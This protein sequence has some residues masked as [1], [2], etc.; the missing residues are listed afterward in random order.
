MPRFP[1]RT[2]PLDQPF[3]QA[4]PAAQP[5]LHE[6]HPSIVALVVVAEQVK[7][8]MKRE[9]PKLVELG[10]AGDARLATGD[11]PGDDDVP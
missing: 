5:P 8:A 4:S 6:L 9:K 3:A 1:D 7:Q 10:M 11:A 2:S